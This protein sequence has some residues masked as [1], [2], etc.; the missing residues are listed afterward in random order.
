MANTKN[1]PKIAALLNDDEEVLS[2]VYEVLY[3]R[4]KTFVYHNKG[5]DEDA[6]DVFHNTLYQLMVRAKLKG[7]QIN[8]SFEAYFFTVSKNLWYKELNKRKKEV[9]SD[10]IL[11]FKSQDDYHVESIL[12]QER[13]DLF[14]EMFLKISDNCQKLLKAYFAKISYDDIIKRFSYST[15]NVAFQRIFKCK[16]ILTKKIREHVKYKDL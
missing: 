11:E 15:K 7:V 12:Y 2:L 8:T 13:W 5:S 1:H 6:E 14:N 10:K 16:A 9:K 3:P 4:V